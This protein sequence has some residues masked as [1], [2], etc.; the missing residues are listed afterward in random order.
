MYDVQPTSDFGF[1]CLGFS[2][3]ANADYWLLKLDSNGCMGNYCGLTDTN[4]FYRPYPDCEDTVG[5]SEV[6][7]MEVQDVRLLVYPN[8]VNDKLTILNNYE[9]LFIY[10]CMGR[11]IMNLQNPQNNNS[12]DIS[13]LSTG[14][15]YLTV[16][17]HNS[18]INT[19]FIKQ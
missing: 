16:S 5:I 3:E 7:N 4:C 11:K 13:D 19:K 14:I 18:T 6:T 10:D 17:N 1:I 12:I 2:H 15:Y 9:H 8:P